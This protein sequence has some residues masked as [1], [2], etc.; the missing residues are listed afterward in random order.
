MFDKSISFNS[1]NFSLRVNWSSALFNILYHSATEDM[2]ADGNGRSS[3]S[4]GQT[5]ADRYRM[6]KQVGDGTFGRSEILTNN[7]NIVI[8]VYRWPRSLTPGI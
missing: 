7:H 5:L 6:T 4:H 1:F 2:T 8:L 3:A